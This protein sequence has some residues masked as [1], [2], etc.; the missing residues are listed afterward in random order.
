M[1]ALP[2]FSPDRGRLCP[3]LKGSSTLE[4]FGI[5]CSKLH[6]KTPSKGNVFTVSLNEG[7]QGRLARWLG[8]LGCE[9]PPPASGTLHPHP[10][11]PVTVAVSIRLFATGHIKVVVVGGWSSGVSV[12]VGDISKALIARRVCFLSATI[13]QRKQVLWICARHSF[14]LSYDF[15]HQWF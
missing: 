14:Y 5:D 7:W 9:I 4:V 15:L 11:A 6:H 1:A 3:W 8:M 10:A 2:L 13:K 12:D